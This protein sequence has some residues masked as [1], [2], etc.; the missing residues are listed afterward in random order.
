MA[1]AVASVQ[2]LDDGSVLVA[3]MDTATDVR[4]RGLL[5][6]THQLQVKPGK[7]GRDYGDEIE[8]VREAA[9]RLLKDAME[10]FANTDP[11]ED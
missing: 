3:Y 2:F 1:L 10:D 5:I 4:N 6:E 9:V 7:G 11:P 8:D